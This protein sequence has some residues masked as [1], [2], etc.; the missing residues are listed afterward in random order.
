LHKKIF[1]KGMKPP[2]GIP[3]S[4]QIPRDEEDDDK[5]EMKDSYSIDNN[6]SLNKGPI[7]ASHNLNMEVKT[8]QPDAD[9]NKFPVPVPKKKL[10]VDF[11]PA[12]WEDYFDKLE[13]LEDGTSIYTAGTANPVFVM[14]HGA[15]HA[16]LSFAC[17]AGEIKKFATAVAFDFRG[18]GL[19][20]IADDK[21]NLKIETLIDDSMK[22]LRYVDKTYPDSTI[23]IVGHSMGG[24][25]ATKL[26]YEA[27]K[28]DLTNKIQG[29]IVIDVVEGTAMEALP[30]MEQVVKSMPKSFKTLEHGIRW[31]IQSG[32]LK[33]IQSARVSI[34]GQ[35][36]EAQNPMTNQTEYV[37]KNDLMAS[38]EYWAGWFK[39]L[40]QTFLDV[41]VPKLLLLA[42]AERMDKELTIAQMQGKFRLKVIYDVGHSIQEDNFIE[43][44]KACYHFLESFKTPLNLSE[45][46][47]IAKNGIGKFHP[48]LPKNPYP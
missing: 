28:T 29:L 38:Q 35:L 19:S 10:G 45:I 26:C 32:T 4:D 8:I 3:K 30:F 47:W 22:I 12:Q 27:L 18:H 48:N 14:L 17:L 42:G 6:P 44:G 39:G 37:W 7:I 25:V 43:T 16:A 1:K 46:D 5:E 11:S 20:K 9:P 13:Y 2:T 15:G 33:N 40:T 23:I 34:P 24:S 36:K 41:R 21:D 31:S